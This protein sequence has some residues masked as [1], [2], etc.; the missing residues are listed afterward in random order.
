MAY[1]HGQ[2]VIQSQ[3]DLRKLRTGRG[4]GKSPEKQ[5]CA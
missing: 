2:I 1:S 4:I 5:A 3:S